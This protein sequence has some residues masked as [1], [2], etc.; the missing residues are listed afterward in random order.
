MLSELIKEIDKAQPKLNN[1][2][3][4]LCKIL[5]KI[6]AP[7]SECETASD[8]DNDQDATAIRRILIEMNHQQPL[9]PTQFYNTTSIS[10][11]NNTLE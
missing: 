9:T 7:V 11:I 8:F 4:M 6:V 2:I 1:P 10:F 5:K 3:H